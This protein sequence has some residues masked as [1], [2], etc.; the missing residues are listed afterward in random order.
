MEMQVRRVTPFVVIGLLWGLSA[1]A[2][3]RVEGQVAG[4]DGGYLE[5]ALVRLPEL[6]LE[7]VTSA[8]GGYAIG[9][10]PAG[11]YEVTVSYIGYPPRSARIDVRDGETTRQK[12]AFSELIEEVVVYGEQTA[13]TASALNQQ[14]AA[15]GIVSVVSA[16]DI[17]QFPDQNV[18][19]ALQ[20]VSGVFLERDQGEGRFVG[21]GGIDPNLFVTTI[22]GVNVPAPENDKRSVALDVI[23]SEL[24]S[25][26]EVSKSITP[27]MDGDG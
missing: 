11:S 24:L 2:D 6:K 8:D 5:G 17:G 25:A 14:R 13:S 22:T 27:D 1:W 19:E 18:S 7:A 12:F 4:D 21:I 16:T 3:G 20:R 15:D 23:P 9:G 10:I 26:L